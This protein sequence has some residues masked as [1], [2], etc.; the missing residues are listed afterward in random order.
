MSPGHAIDGARV[1]IRTLIWRPVPARG[2]LAGE[3]TFGHRFESGPASAVVDSLAP[4]QNPDG[5]FKYMLTSGGS[6]WPRSAAGVATLYRSTHLGF[7]VTDGS[8]DFALNDTFTVTVARVELD[9]VDVPV[10]RGHQ[11]V[12][13][14]QPVLAEQAGDVVPAV[15]GHQRVVG[16]AA[17]VPELGELRRPGLRQVG[18]HCLPG[19]PQKPVGLKES[20]RLILIGIAGRPLGARVG[21]PRQPVF[22]FQQLQH[23]PGIAY[24]VYL[25]V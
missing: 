20:S 24:M 13:Q 12:L 7:T 5:G 15:R 17:D 14:R 23:F 11:D 9:A 18:G 10:A 21:G 22:L 25:S 3:V 4:F 19:R 16:L 6:A 1:S 8:V 2:R